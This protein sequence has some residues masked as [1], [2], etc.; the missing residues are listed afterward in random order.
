MKKILILILVC[1]ASIYCSEESFDQYKG[2]MLH[3]FIKSSGSE[4]T[5]WLK[6]L[7]NDQGHLRKTDLEQTDCCC[8][9][10][11]PLC[12]AALSGQLDTVEI[13]LKAKFGPNLEFKVNPN[14]GFRKYDPVFGIYTT[15]PILPA[16]AR[17]NINESRKLAIFKRLFK[18]RANP[19][20]KD[21]TGRSA[22]MVLLALSKTDEEA[23]KSPI[24]KLLWSK[25]E[26]TREDY[27]KVENDRDIFLK[28]EQARL[29]EEETLRIKRKRAAEELDKEIL[30]DTKRICL[31]QELKSIGIEINYPG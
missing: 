22:L 16:L 26:F 13:L 23:Q 2:R 7:L 6:D 15:A 17:A 30:A 14:S 9:H 31:K 4:T 10:K 19:N 3:S 27:D 5:E 24:G 25:S 28:K 20:L 12:A 11:T 21:E 8:N 29:L 1:T 18:H